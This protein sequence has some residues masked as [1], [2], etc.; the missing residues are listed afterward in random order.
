M[1]ESEYILL[2]S[3]RF[4]GEISLE[5]ST[6]LDEWLSQSPENEQFAQSTQ[7]IWEKSEGY[8]R[9]FSPDLNADFQ[10]IQARIRVSEAP[11]A[12][13]VTL[14]QKLMRVAAVMALLLAAVWSWQ[15]F[16]HASAAAIMVSAENTGMEDVKLPDGSQIWL[17]KGSQLEYASKWNGE[18]RE[19]KLRGEAYFEIQHDPAHPFKVMLENGG[20]VEVLGTQFNVR[21][22]SKQTMVLVRSGKVRFSPS[23]QTAGPVLTANQKA[24]FD[25]D[26]AQMQIATVSSLN[27]LSWQTG[28]LEFVNTPLVQV[29]RDLEQYYGVQITLGNPAMAT[30]PHSAPL[31]NQSIEKVLETIALTHQLKLKKTGDKAYE[32]SEGQCH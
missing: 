16:S 25:Q 28:G 3:K 18:A 11:Q 31:T 7:R 20:T 24:V 5:E 2:L 19:V 4:S 14:G 15:Q 8:V 26:A 17:R 1:N 30:C 23:A 13:T 6:T 22:S 21:Q 29:V 32:L 10:K 12:L 27:E 9:N